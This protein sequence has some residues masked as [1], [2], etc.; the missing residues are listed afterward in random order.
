MR[1]KNTLQKKQKSRTLQ[2]RSR[3]KDKTKKRTKKRVTKKTQS[4]G[5]F[6]EI[7]LIISVLSVAGLYTLRKILRDMNYRDEEKAKSAKSAEAEAAPLAAADVR[8]HVL[9]S[10]SRNTRMQQWANTSVSA[11]E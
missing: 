4:G 7:A 11:H 5:S 2:K 10:V 6:S 3:I 8:L 1:K 9:R